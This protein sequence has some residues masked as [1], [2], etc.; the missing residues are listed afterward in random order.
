[1][2]KVTITEDYLENIADAIR[3][4][5][6]SSNTYTPAQMAPAI[7]AIPTGGGGGGVDPS[8]ATAT[9]ADILSPK[10]AYIASG[11]VTGQIQSKTASIYTPTTAN[12]VIA[13]GV[14]L[15][16]SQT[17]L[18]DTN[19]VPSKIANGVTI[20]GVEGTYEGGGITTG[21]LTVTPTGSQQT[22]TGGSQK[23]VSRIQRSSGGSTVPLSSTLIEGETY[24]GKLQCYFD[25][26]YSPRVDYSSSFI[27]SSSGV[28]FY[29][30]SYVVYLDS[31]QLKSTQYDHYYFYVYTVL[32]DAFTPVTVEAIS[33]TYVGSGIPR[34]TS[35]SLTA[36]GSSIIVPS[37]Y[38]ASES[39]KSVSIGTVVPSATITGTNANLSTGTGTLTLSKTVSNT[40]NV[41]TAGY[42][43]GG[44]AGNTAV[45][46][47]ANVAINPT[48]TASG[49][50]VT[51][52]IGYYSTAGTKSISAGTV[53]PASSITGTSASVSI[54]S[55]TVTL[56]KIISNTPNVSTAGYINAGTAGNSSISL[57][58]SLAIQHY[59]TGTSTPSS[60]LG[61]NGDI[62]LKT[63]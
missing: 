14:Y 54:G 53:V 52:P 32:P 62:Y 4:K 42:V 30:S 56:T 5:N 44:T 2:T 18:G 24:I 51:A 25:D 13:S 37:G 31:I 22:F 55:G 61:E 45:S 35:A 57:T 27:A 59:Y 19:L 40:P 6:G 26:D 15:S 41:S 47:T 7:Q 34:R 50:I 58:G 20:F 63:S 43:S 28:N 48:L 23:E 60:S 49:S 11:K 39:L 29:S 36:S 33:S 3:S 10:T 21:S 12:Q 17:I 8:D 1:M 9:A 16:G 38:Y 46:L